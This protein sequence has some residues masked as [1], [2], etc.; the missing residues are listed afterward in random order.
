[1]DA[2]KLSQTTGENQLASLSAL[3]AFKAIPGRLNRLLLVH[4]GDDREVEEFPENMSAVGP[5]LRVWDIIHHDNSFDHEYFRTQLKDIAPISTFNTSDTSTKISREN[6]VL[7]PRIV[8]G[9]VL[10]VRQWVNFEMRDMSKARFNKGLWKELQLPVGYKRSLL[11]TVR[12]HVRAKEPQFEY[13]SVPGKGAGA[14]ILLQGSSGVGKTFTAEALSNHTNRPLYS[15][16]SGDLGDS[17]ATVERQLAKILDHG[18]RWGCIILLDEA[19]VYLT[20]RGQESF[21]R[22]AIVSVFLRQ[23]EWYPGLMVL[24]TNRHLDLDEAITQRFQLRLFYPPLNKNAVGRIWELYCTEEKCQQ[25]IA[26]RVSKKPRVTIS[27]GVYKWWEIQYEKTTKSKQ[28]TAS[29]DE[30]NGQPWWSGRDI[31][32]AFR[33]VIALAVHDKVTQKISDVKTKSL[34]L[35]D[36]E[37]KLKKKKS[38]KTRSEKMKI[39][40]E[41]AHKAAQN[42]RI[43]TEEDEILITTALFDEVLNRLKSFDEGIKTMPNEQA[44]AP[45]KSP[46]EGLRYSNDDI[47]ESIIEESDVSSSDSTSDGDED[48]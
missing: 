2:P 42:S 46:D 21:E 13:D 18:R 29:T 39:M 3:L 9:F 33:E 16:T 36:E 40:K 30:Q 4:S 10:S 24:T 28:K 26:D 41:E 5:A 1:M 25:F 17:V 44:G 7:F 43:I 32:F 48:P 23:L 22:N 45:P 11:A 6:F 14:I 8:S 34:I 15:I 31:Q 47:N 20:R 19:D 35:F 37:S 38:S 12:T 27:D